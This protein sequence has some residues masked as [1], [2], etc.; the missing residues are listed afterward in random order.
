MLWDQA[1]FHTAKV[2]RTPEN[3][4]IIEPSPYSPELNPMENLWHCLQSYYWSNRTYEDYEALVDA[5]TTAWRTAWL[6]HALVSTV[7]AATY[8]KERT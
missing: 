7:C 4:T 3:V 6:D 2:V 8:L 1:E 5:T